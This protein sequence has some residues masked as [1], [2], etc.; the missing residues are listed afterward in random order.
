[1][2]VMQ[3][4]EGNFDFRK[5]KSRF[6][7]TYIANGGYDAAR[8]EEA[9]RNGDADLVSFGTMFVANP[10]LVRRFELDAPLNKMD[11]T[12]FYQGEERGYT[13]YPALAAA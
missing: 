10:D 1:M 6:G 13:D 9:I 11:P 2:D 8:A 4:G 7:G 12:T 5:L 3:L